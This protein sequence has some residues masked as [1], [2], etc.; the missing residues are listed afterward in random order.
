VSETALNEL[1]SRDVSRLRGATLELGPDNQVVVRHGIVRAT[2]TLR[3]AVDM[4]SSPRATVTLASVIVAMGLKAL[5]REPY[6][7]V[8]GRELTIHL[9]AVPALEPFRPIWPYVRRIEVTTERG[10][11]RLHFELIVTGVSDA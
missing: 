7:Q 3:Q 10:R 2:A 6:I 4:G 1:L 11:L 8:R 5:L 9:A